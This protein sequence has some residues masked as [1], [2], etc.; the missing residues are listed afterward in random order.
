MKARMVLCLLIAVLM[1][2][3]MSFSVAQVRVSGDTTYITGGTYVGAENIGLMEAT[4][5]NDTLASGA[6]KNIHMV[7]ALY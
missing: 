1:T 4:I 2:S 6:R 7:Y 3:F 5:N